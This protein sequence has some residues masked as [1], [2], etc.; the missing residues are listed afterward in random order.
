MICQIFA[1]KK[2]MIKVLYNYKIEDSKTC[3]S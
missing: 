2:F 1:E 3:E